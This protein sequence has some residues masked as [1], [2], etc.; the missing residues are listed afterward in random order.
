MNSR[1]LLLVVSGLLFMG[2]ICLVGIGGLVFIAGSGILP[3][4]QAAMVED[5]T[6]KSG[7]IATNPSN[8]PTFS[9]PVDIPDDA[10]AIIR[11]EEEVLG[12]IYYNSVPS[13]VNIRISG[14]VNGFLGEAGEGSGFV[15]DSDGHIVTN[16][17]VVEGAQSIVVTFSDS[18][19]A[20]AE[21][22]GTDPDSDLAVIKVEVDPALLR[23]VSP[24][25]SAELR[26]GQRVIAIGNPFG[27]DNTMTAGVI[28]AIGRTIPGQINELGSFS[29]PNMIQTDAAIN[30]GN[31]GGPLFDIDGSVIG[32]NSLIYS[33]TPGANSGVGFAIPIDKVLAVVPSIITDG[34][35]ET[36]YLGLMSGRDLIL[37]AELAEL[38]QLPNVTFGIL[39][40]EVIPGGPSDQAGLRGS[41]RE[42]QV[43]ELGGPII[44]G[45]DVVIAIDEVRVE[46]FDD[47]IN[48]LDTRRVGDVVTLTIIRDGEQQQLP[49]TL[50]SR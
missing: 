26:V 43:P 11:A 13:V 35:Y 38:L 32:V 31:S 25:N 46:K 22:V 1:A 6:P 8:T 19:Q 37:T 45:G 12:A 10:V 20:S 48:Y 42:I 27:F 40:T 21:V 16:N 49:V 44:T 28:S 4:R 2:L 17:H 9:D 5:S 15:W 7:E 47:L 50:G 3:E 14:E 24:G 23:P 34:A 33:E 30:P 39:V 29:L 36:P 41:T 18:T